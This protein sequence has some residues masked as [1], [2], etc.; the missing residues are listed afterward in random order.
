V[1]L[2]DPQRAALNAA[3][4]GP[5]FRW[6]AGWAH[7]GGDLHATPVIQALSRRKLLAINTLAGVGGVASITAAGRRLLSP[8]PSPSPQGGGEQVGA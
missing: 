6:R 5:L 2:S 7:S 3:A 4:R 8:A 1:R